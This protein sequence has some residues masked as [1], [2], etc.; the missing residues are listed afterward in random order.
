MRVLYPSKQA[1]RD[2][3][4]SGQKASDQGASDQS[5]SATLQAADE[6]IEA[7]DDNVEASDDDAEDS[8]PSDNG[9]EEPSLL[10]IGDQDDTSVSKEESAEGTG[11]IPW[12]SQW[13]G[14]RHVF[15][16]HDAR[17][18]LQ[19]Y[20][21]ATGLDTGCVYGRKLTACVIPLLPKG[22]KVNCVQ[23]RTPTLAEL[24]AEI[25]SVN[26]KRKYH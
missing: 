3:S 20:D 23:H 8:D 4:A 12:A 17:K 7:S 5:T 1:A 16:G 6:E 26:A 22:Q 2:Q 25:V 9:Q 13:A 10:D 15:F 11:S 21:Y 24:R 19:T 14:P 18:G